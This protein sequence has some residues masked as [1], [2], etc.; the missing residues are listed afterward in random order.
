MRQERFEQSWMES[1]NS[2]SQVSRGSWMDELAKLWPLPIR[3]SVC[4][5]GLEKLFA[6]R[7]IC[8]QSP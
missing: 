1:S 8:L 6:T 7:N 5:E 3:P 4:A 2:I